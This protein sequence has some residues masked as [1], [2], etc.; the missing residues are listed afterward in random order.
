MICVN[1]G[2][3]DGSAAVLEW[4]ASCDPRLRVLHQSNA[5]I[6]EALNKGIAAAQAPLICRMDCDDVALP[7]RLE[8]QTRYLE[9]HP[10]C[11]VVGASILEIDADNDPLQVSR[12]PREHA[13]ILNNLLHRRTGHFHPT[14]MIRSAALQAVGGYRRR[15]QWVEDHDLWL[16][17]SDRGELANLPDILL[18]Y[19]QHVGSVCWQ[20]TELQRTLMNELLSEAY[21]ARS[22]AVPAAVIIKDSITRSTAGPGKWARAAAKGGNWRNALKHLAALNRG[23]APVAYKA[24]MSFEIAA[25]FLISRLRQPDSGALD[26]IVPPSFPD[27]HARWE[28]QS[29]HFGSPSQAAQLLNAPVAC[30]R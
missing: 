2:S 15:Y 7:N 3:T 17:L 18:C 27:W 20:R 25:R 22:Q 1:D 24:R 6:V 8:L 21:Q 12:L 5:G 11:V 19:R 30:A 14:T 26:N 10:E 4:F 28:T 13:A 29:T 9:D 23:P 16:R